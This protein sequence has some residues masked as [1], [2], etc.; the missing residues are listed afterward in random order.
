MQRQAVVTVRVVLNEDQDL[1]DAEHEVCNAL[2]EYELM[3]HVVGERIEE[4]S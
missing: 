2:E 3:A 1:D 4:V